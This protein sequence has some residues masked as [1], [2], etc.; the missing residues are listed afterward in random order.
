MFKIIINLNFGKKIG[1]LFVKKGNQIEFDG[2]FY[3][4]CNT[5]KSGDPLTSY[6]YDVNGPGHGV[7][8]TTC[9]TNLCNSKPMT[10]NILSTQAVT[11]TKEMSRE[12]TT[13]TTT[14]ELP[15]ECLNPDGTDCSWYEVCLEEKYNCKNT[16]ADYAIKYAKKFC[17]LYSKNYESFSSVGQQWVDGVR[18]C[19]QQALLLI[20]VDD[21]HI[22]TCQE[23][24]QIAFDSHAPC[25]L[26]PGPGMPSI[27]DITC[28]DWF[29]VFFTISSSFVSEPKESLKG[30]FKVAKSCVLTIAGCVSWKIPVFIYNYVFQINNGNRFRMLNE[31]EQ[32]YIESL[33]LFEDQVG[34]SIASQLKIDSN[35]FSW[36]AYIESSNEEILQDNRL[37]VSFW[38]VDLK[39]LHD[40]FLTMFS[41][42]FQKV[43][44]SLVET[45]H[46]GK[47]RLSYKLENLKD[48][49]WVECLSM[50]TCLDIECNEKNNYMQY[51]Y[52]KSSSLAFLNVFI[53]LAVALFISF[54]IE[55]LLF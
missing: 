23:I 28:R 55:F 31:Q 54:N 15:Y 34:D 2:I 37:N 36:F 48:E 3:R 9:L 26:N 6:L 22:Y 51:F 20:L 35:E 42:K 41:E 27:C 50:E 25:Y 13:T 12:T 38:I 29:R 10:D 18:R 40:N 4:Y 1:R 5:Y 45:F 44:Q 53:Q 32:A 39:D 16:P 49:A 8:V 19:L 43:N 46:D 33:R 7:E 11:T 24:K 47:L 14:T 17:E 52:N 30:I 21:T